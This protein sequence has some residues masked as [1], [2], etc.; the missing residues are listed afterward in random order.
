[1]HPSVLLGIAVLGMVALGAPDS[2]GGPSCQGAN[3][4]VA[5]QC[6]RLYGGADFHGIP[7]CP[8]GDGLDVAACIRCVGGAALGIPACDEGISGDKYP[9]TYLQ[10]IAA[11]SGVVYARECNTCHCM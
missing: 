10:C 11:N 2:E 3:S 8:A 9:E 5:A 6:Q 4:T 1:M 7:A